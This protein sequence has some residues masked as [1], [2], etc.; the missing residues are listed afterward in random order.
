MRSIISVWRVRGSKRVV[1]SRDTFEAINFTGKLRYII[2][3]EFP[4]GKVAGFIV[5]HI[6]GGVV[7]YIDIICSNTGIGSEL[8][9]EAIKIA[10][11]ENYFLIALR[12][13]Y[14]GK[15]MLH[16]EKWG[17][18]Q[19]CADK[20]RTKMT[21]RNDRH[22]LW[23]LNKSAAEFVGQSIKKGS[24]DGWFMSKSLYEPTKDREKLELCGKIH[25]ALA[26]NVDDNILRK[27]PKQKTNKT[28]KCVL[29]R[30]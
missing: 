22:L 9:K 15:L 13:A 8:E 17:Y 30:I 23:N 25:K 11:K 5:A 3:A 6:I 21:R 27:K 29:S 12:S 10:K 20:Y 28:R 7:F 19:S 14:K 2:W 4:N 26:V 16:Y 1:I 18:T 24:G